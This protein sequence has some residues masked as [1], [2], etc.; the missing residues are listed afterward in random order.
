MKTH[1]IKSTLR[2]EDKWK[3][4]KRCILKNMERILGKSKE[5]KRKEWRNDEILE[6]I[7]ER[8]I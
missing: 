5:I 1:D 4:I 6:M 8:R 7:N 2:I 3:N